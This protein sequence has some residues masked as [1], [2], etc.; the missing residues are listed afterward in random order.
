MLAPGSQ[1]QGPDAPVFIDGFE[2]ISQRVDQLD[3]EE[4]VWRPTDFYQRNV[5]VMLDVQIVV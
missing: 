5:A 2:G 1:H 4:V 3:V